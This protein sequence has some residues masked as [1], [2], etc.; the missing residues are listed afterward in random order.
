MAV[1]LGLNGCLYLA[2]EK[3]GGAFLVPVS[4]EKFVHLPNDSWDTQSNAMI[5]IYRP[6]SEWASDEID[7]PSVY[8][9]DRHYVNLRANGYSWLELAP[10]KR[11]VTMRRPVGLLLGF[12]GMGH[13]ALDLIVDAEFDVEPGKVY[14]FRYSEVELPEKANPELDPEHPLANG[15]MQ[16]VSRDVAIKEIVLTRYM[17][18]QPPFAKN[19]A[20]KSIVEVNKTDDYKKTKK[21]LEEEREV[22][23]AKLKSEGHWRESK[24]YWPFGS[25]PTKRLK[26]DVELKKLDKARDQHLAMLEEKKAKKSWWPFK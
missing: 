4:G 20:G 11:R 19:N 7:A 9:D 15:D 25:G 2:L 26:T 3:H 14:Y 16:L 5:Y 18:N 13:F 24:W 23:L 8:I 12:E 22:E 1:A 10:G 21:Q 6:D 17:E